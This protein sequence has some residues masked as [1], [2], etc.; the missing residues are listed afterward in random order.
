VIGGAGIL[1]WLAVIVLGLLLVGFL[2]V[3]RPRIRPSATAL[4]PEEPEDEVGEDPERL[5]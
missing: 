5:L 3:L 2:L 1:L 4:G